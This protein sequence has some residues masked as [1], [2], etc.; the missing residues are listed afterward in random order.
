MFSPGQTAPEL[1]DL[2]TPKKT[3]RSCCLTAFYAMRYNKAARKPFSKPLVDVTVG[4]GDGLEKMLLHSGDKGK[5]QKAY[6]D[7]SRLRPANQK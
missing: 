5:E 7:G 6:G 2:F 1:Y 4:I 3:D